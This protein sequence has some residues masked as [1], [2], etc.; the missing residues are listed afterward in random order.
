ML[1]QES[2]DGLVLLTWLPDRFESTG[3]SVQEKKLNIDFEDAYLGEDVQ[4]SGGH[5]VFPIATIFV[6]FAV[7]VTLCF[8][9][10]FEWIGFSI[11]EKKRKID[12]QNSAMEAILD[13]RSEWF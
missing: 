8:L 9:S 12:F 4:N 3:F 5:L 6:I 7:Q 13:F 11:Q 1:K 10:S 2:Q